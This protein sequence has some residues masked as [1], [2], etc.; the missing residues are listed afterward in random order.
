[1]VGCWFTL[2]K[3]EREIEIISSLKRSSEVLSFLTIL[4]ANE[5]MPAKH[6]LHTACR[7]K[8]ADNTQVIDDKNCYRQPY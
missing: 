8:I 6:N 1:M 2:A 7:V 4:S 5:I 3:R